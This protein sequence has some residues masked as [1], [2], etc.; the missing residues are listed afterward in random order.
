[1]RA[2]IAAILV[3]GLAAAAIGAAQGLSDLESERPLLMEDA[4]P[5]SYRAFSGSADFTYSIRRDVSDDFGPGFSLAYGLLR[6]LE[7]GA[8]IRWVTSPEGNAERGVSSGDLR[9]QSLYQIVDETASRPA[10]A[11]RAGVQF[12]TGLDSKG[13]DLHLA[14]LVTRSFD[15]FRLHANF[16]Y[17]RLGDSN[18]NE[19]RDRLEGIAGIDFVPPGRLGVTDTLLLADASVR[20]N[21]VVGESSIVTLEFG[22]R[23]RIG[24]QTVFF[25]GAGSEIGATHDR[26]RLTLR[27]GLTHQY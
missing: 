12:P 5:I 2:R 7:V 9:L 8:A 22:V 26:S 25:A 20:S 3:T 10:I 4:R 27:V 17:V 21:P 14:L 15:A 19:K 6:G 24:A 13:T 16:R 11:I 1:V 23:H 18:T